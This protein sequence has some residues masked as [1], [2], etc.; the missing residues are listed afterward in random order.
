MATF[1][2]RGLYFEE[3]AV[4]QELETPGRTVTEADVVSFAGL[5]GDFNPL[6]TDAE[7][8][9]GTPYGQRIAHGLLG[10]AIASGLADRAGF[11]EGTALAFVGL[12]WK[13][14]ASILIGDTIRL[15]TRVIKTR[16]MRSM[17][18][19]MVVFAV[20]VLNQRDERVQQGEW[21]ML[22]RGQDATAT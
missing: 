9:K 15:H 21:T 10:L 1:E 13:F 6:H 17:G 5:S 4:D 2:R 19:G 8:A 11:I 20:T 22:I 14:K 7:F 3:F 18:G 12:E 16:P